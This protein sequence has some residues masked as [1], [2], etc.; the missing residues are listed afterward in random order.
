MGIERITKAEFI[1]LSPAKDPEV[2]QIA[3]EMGWFAD[4][5]KNII[6][7]ILLDHHDKDWN[8]VVLGRDEEGQFRW[9]AGDSSFATQEKAEGELTAA[10]SK[11]E[12]SGETVF[13]Q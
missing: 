10:M 5:K 8:Y 11:F 13:P 6:G 3:T 7:A 1:P 2:E 12:E 9:I 4:T